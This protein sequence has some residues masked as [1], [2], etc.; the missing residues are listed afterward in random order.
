MDSAHPKTYISIKVSLKSAWWLAQNRLNRIFRSQKN[1]EVPLTQFAKTTVKTS[2]DPIWD[3]NNQLECSK[4]MNKHAGAVGFTISK[5]KQKKRDLWVPILEENL[6]RATLAPPRRFWHS[7][8]ILS[9]IFRLPVFLTLLVTRTRWLWGQT[10]SLWWHL[11]TF[12]KG[13]GG[14]K[15][16][17]QIKGLDLK[18]AMSL[19]HDGRFHSFK[20][21]TLSKQ[22]RRS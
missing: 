6:P 8:W 22:T 16:K 18:I 1:T 7:H 9:T 11:L 13:T 15:P 4:G 10:I 21:C 2:L 14:K 20:C 3:H 12:V 5:Q 19:H 17:F